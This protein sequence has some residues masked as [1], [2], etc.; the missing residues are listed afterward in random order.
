VA[1]A[2]TTVVFELGVDAASSGVSLGAADSDLFDQPCLWRV[3]AA[4][5]LGLSSDDMI[6]VMSP[7]P[8]FPA[9]LRSLEST[10]PPFPDVIVDL[11]AGGGGVSE[12]LRR[13]TGATVYAIEP[14]LGARQAAM[15]AFPDLRVLEGRADKAPLEEGIANAVTISGVLSLMPHIDPVIREVDRLLARGGRF[16]IA[17]LFS[18]DAATWSSEPNIFR[19]VEAVMRKLRHHGFTAASVGCGDPVPDATWAESARAVDDWIEAHCAD[20]PGYAE[21]DTDRRHL[22][23]QI[24]SGNLIGGCLIAERASTRSKK[25]IA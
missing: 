4:A 19:S 6:A 12:W 8:A 10:L 7:G 5:A 17:D 23:E 20:R 24:A 11:G 18:R 15:L 9:A 3:E 25:S 1:A 2:T 22:R 14:A 21:W 16:A 13:S